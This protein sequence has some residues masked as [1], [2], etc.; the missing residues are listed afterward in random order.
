MTAPKLL[1]ELVLNGGSS[2]FDVTDEVMLKYE[3][4][5]LRDLNI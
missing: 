1:S 4:R 2:R 5:K 3:Q